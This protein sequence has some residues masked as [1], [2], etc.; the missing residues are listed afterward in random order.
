MKDEGSSGGLERVCQVGGFCFK[1]FFGVYPVLFLA[2][3]WPFLL[4]AR[5]V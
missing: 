2:Q 1:F 4:L 3:P 5:R